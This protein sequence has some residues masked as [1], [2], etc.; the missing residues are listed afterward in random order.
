[1][2][3]GDELVVA[4]AEPACGTRAAAASYAVAKAAAMADFDRRFLRDLLTRASGNIT[5][6]AAEA[7]KDRR[8]FGRLV[9]K[10]GLRS[11]DFRNP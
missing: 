6:A 4:T 9:K 8:A 3:D 5:R 7:G 11:V 10:Y 1:M 2:A